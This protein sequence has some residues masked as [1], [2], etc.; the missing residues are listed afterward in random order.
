MDDRAQAEEVP[1]AY[2]VQKKGVEAG[3]G[4]EKR[5]VEWLAGKVASCISGLEG[6]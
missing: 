6:V 4:T 2:V 1:R 5:I 3:A